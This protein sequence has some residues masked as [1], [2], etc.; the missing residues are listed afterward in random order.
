MIERYIMVHSILVLALAAGPVGVLMDESAGRVFAQQPDVEHRVTIRIQSR[1]FTPSTLKIPRNQ[2]IRLIL[3]NQDAELHAFVPIGVFAKTNLQISGTGAPQFGKEGLVRIVLPSSG[4]T[5]VVFMPQ[6]V[7]VYP[8]FCDMP[9]HTM[10]GEIV[11][12]AEKDM[13]Q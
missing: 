7:G 8:Y 13:V 11:V 12:E 10:N 3:E 5:E 1:L 9:G 6:H 4:Q 2:K